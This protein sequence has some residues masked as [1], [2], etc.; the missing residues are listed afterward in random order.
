ML[1]SSLYIDSFNSS[2]TLFTTKE[3]VFYIVVRFFNKASRAF[4]VYNLSLCYFL[5]L[6]EGKGEEE[7]SKVAIVA[8]IGRGCCLKRV[9]TPWRFR[10]ILAIPLSG[11][12]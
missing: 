1:R 7:E 12:N 3:I 11:E 2:A 9:A 8:I 6:I 5:L 4:R 10:A